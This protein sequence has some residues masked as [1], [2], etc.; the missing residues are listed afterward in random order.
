[1]ID[2]A[3]KTSSLADRIVEVVRNDEIELPPFP[4]LAVQLQ[5]LLAREDADAGKVAE[6]V[7][8]DPAVVARLLRVANS[9]AFGG[10]Q[11]ITDPKQAI[12]RLGLS[13]VG[14][15]CSALLV[16]G[17][18]ESGDSINKDVIDKLWDHSVTTAF[19]ARILA[20]EA[21]ADK[22]S[23]FLG[24]L[25]H[26]CGKLLVIRAV[27]HLSNKGV[28]IGATENLLEELMN[29]LHCDLGHMA[30]TIWKL[31]EP[32]PEIAKHHEDDAADIEDPVMLCVMAGD[33]ITQKLGFDLDPDPNMTLLQEPAVDNL[34]IDDMA[35]A[36]L[37]ID[38]E[39]RLE[40]LR[41]AF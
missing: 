29:K 40:K 7:S 1:M 24:G 4:A 28:E 3:E 11:E 16:K 17:Q 12:A 33:L 26:D 14:A 13:Q 19:A 25:L 2:A 6:T 23:A 32:L 38:L 18:F 31:P 27:D 20:E 37:M 39:D 34:G 41:E 35:L 5:E 15:V 30:L 10:L 36:T 9:A 21:G 8:I 22:T